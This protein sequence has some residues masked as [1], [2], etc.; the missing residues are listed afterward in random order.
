MSI[1][2]AKNPFKETLIPSSDGVT[3][4]FYTSQNYKSGS[5]ALWLNG[6]KKIQPWEDGF[7]ETG[8]KEITMNE[9]PLTGDSV[10]AEYQPL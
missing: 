9:A 1:V 4:K 3:Q 6:I 7:T 2:A 8:S 10:Q 5:V